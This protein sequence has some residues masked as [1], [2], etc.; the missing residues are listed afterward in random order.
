MAQGI[1]DT[2][3]LMVGVPAVLIT[4]QHFAVSFGPFKC[5]LHISDSSFNETELCGRSRVAELP[6]EAAKAYSTV[7]EGIYYP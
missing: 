7:R 4:T 1:K 3:L 5:P 6:D 2:W